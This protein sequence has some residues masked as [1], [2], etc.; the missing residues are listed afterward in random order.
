MSVVVSY[1]SAYAVPTQAMRGCFFMNAIKRL[2]C[3]A[4]QLVFRAALPILPYRQPQLLDHLHKIAPLLE[5]KQVSS[6]LLHTR[7]TIVPWL[8]LAA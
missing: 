4:Y 8:R 6:G 1:S 7:D 2:Y 5:Q 3:R